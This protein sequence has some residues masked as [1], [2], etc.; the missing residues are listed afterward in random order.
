MGIVH[1]FRKGCG[2][3]NR[4]AALIAAY[5]T[6]NFFLEVKIYLDNPPREQA[7]DVTPAMEPRGDFHSRI[8]FLS[9]NENRTKKAEIAL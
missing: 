6:S 9:G 4:L 7:F 5:Q 2:E 8:V 3:I 1:F